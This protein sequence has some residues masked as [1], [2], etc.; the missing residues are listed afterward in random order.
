[1]AQEMLDNPATRAEAIQR[2][3]QSYDVDLAQLVGQP[4]QQQGSEQTAV[5]DLFKDS[6]VDALNQEIAG[7]KQMIQRLGGTVSAR[8]QAEQQRMEQQRAI[9][10]EAVAKTIETFAQGKPYFKDIEEDLVHEVNFIKSKEPG[11]SADKVLEKAYDRALYANSQIRERV[12]H[13]QRKAEADK[14]AK[15]LAAK[16]A[17]AKK[18]QAMNVR[19]G[20]SASTPAFDGR[21]DDPDALGAIYDRVNAR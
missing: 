8:E 16:Q 6:R 11:L 1:M 21:W 3:A 20:A 2:L 19:T 15:E 18:A 10:T 4:K 17:A 12:L 5:D 7:L 9:Q 13:D 14:A